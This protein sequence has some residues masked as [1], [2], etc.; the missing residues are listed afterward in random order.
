MMFMDTG[1]HRYYRK[2]F[3]SAPNGTGTPD[4]YRDGMQPPR[5]EKCHSGLFLSCKHLVP[6]RIKTH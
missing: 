5:L 2:T 6:Y 4:G 1:H 3:A